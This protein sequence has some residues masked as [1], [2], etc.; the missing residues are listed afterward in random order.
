MAFGDSIADTIAHKLDPWLRNPPDFDDVNSAYKRRG[1]LKAEKERLQRQINRVEDGVVLET[2]KPRSNTTRIAKLEATKEL[3][4]QLAELS[5]Q[6]EIADNDV[7]LLEFRLGM[8]KV[9]SYQQ[10]Q[11]FDL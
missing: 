1:L 7:K 6:I 9:A 2:D 3:R 5:A 8:Y 4:D 10:K 11:A